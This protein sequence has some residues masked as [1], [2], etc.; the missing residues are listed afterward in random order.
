M[1]VSRPTRTSTTSSTETS[2]PRR[3]KLDPSAMVIAIDHEVRTFAMP[4]TG[5]P[6]FEKHAQRIARAGIYDLNVH[7]EQ[8]LVPVVMRQWKVAEMTGLNAEAETARDRLIRYLDRMAKVSARAWHDA[9]RSAPSPPIQARC[10][11]RGGGA[12]GWRS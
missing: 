5:I 6:D 3:S 10:T 12:G 1:A 11:G 2:R 8:I 4:G 9:S 7:H